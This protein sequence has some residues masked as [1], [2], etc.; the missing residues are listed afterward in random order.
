M[1]ILI[2]HQTRYEKVKEFIETTKDVSELRDLLIECIDNYT[3]DIHSDI[4]NKL[5]DSGKIK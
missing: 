2:D 5:C 1:K 4:Y 3:T